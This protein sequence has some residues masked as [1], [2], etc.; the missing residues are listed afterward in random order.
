MSVG[1]CHRGQ[2]KGTGDTT[3]TRSWMP[4]LPNLSSA[5]S[6]ALQSQFLILKMTFPHLFW[7]NM[8]KK[9]LSHQSEW[10]FQWTPALNPAAFYYFEVRARIS[11]FVLKNKYLHEVTM[12]SSAW[13]SSWN[14]KQSQQQYL[15]LGRNFLRS[16]GAT[17][18]VLLSL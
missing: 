9:N 11:K 1:V 4:A 15:A 8:L 18:S 13:E 12:T 7:F 16:S 5:Q 14:R 3:Y 17:A 6:S 10:I 2:L